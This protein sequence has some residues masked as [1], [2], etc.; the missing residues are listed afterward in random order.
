MNLTLCNVNMA[1]VHLVTVARQSVVT[2]AHLVT[3]ARQWVT[4]AVHLVTIRVPG[5]LSLLPAT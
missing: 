3:V 2:V 4:A 5:T 1:A